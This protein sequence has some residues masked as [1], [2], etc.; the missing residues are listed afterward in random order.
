MP[1]NTSQ[2]CFIQ[3]QHK[4]HYFIQLI[5][6]Q[7]K[8]IYVSQKAVINISLC[9]FLYIFTKICNILII[10]KNFLFSYI[11]KKFSF[12]GVLFSQI[13]PVNEFCWIELFTQPCI[14]GLKRFSLNPFKKK[15][16]IFEKIFYTDFCIRFSNV[17]TAYTW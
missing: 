9:Y 13:A 16:S 3:I 17:S 7:I 2:N 14:F 4:T 12:C 11:K 1:L 10:F 5:N 6:I 15:F 8:I